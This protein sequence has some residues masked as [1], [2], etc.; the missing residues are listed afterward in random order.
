MF[1]QPCFW[2]RKHSSSVR[3]WILCSL[4]FLSLVS[5]VYIAFDLPKLHNHILNIAI[6]G[7]SKWFAIFSVSIAPVLL[8]V[9]SLRR[10]WFSIIC[11]IVA[12]MGI[13]RGFCGYWI[14]LCYG[15]GAWLIRVCFLFSATICSV[16]LWWLIIRKYLFNILPSQKDSLLLAITLML[17]S[18]VDSFYVSPFITHLS[19][20]F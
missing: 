13:C 15:S 8:C 14:F 1:L 10:N 20:Y 11:L 9:V 12:L 19:M 17:F 5:G 16:I 4:W 18:L 7:T 6:T 2:N 3:F